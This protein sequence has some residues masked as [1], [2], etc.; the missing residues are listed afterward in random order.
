MIVENAVEREL[1][2]GGLVIDSP[3]S[4]FIYWFENGCQVRHPSILFLE[5]YLLTFL[6][7]ARLARNSESSLRYERKNRYA[8]YYYEQQY[9]IRPPEPIATRGVTRAN[10]KPQGGQGREQKVTAETNCW[11]KC[12]DTG[13]HGH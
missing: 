11:A 7:A 6:F 2:N 1:T 3:R 4:Y 8:G 13:V 12:D 9:G 5:T 10:K